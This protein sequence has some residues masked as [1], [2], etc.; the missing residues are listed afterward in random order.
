MISETIFDDGTV[1]LVPYPELRGQVKD[2]DLLLCSGN[3]T[4]SKLI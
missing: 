1:D 3:A 2:G 4:F